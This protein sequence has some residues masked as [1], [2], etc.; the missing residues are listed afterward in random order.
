MLEI[1]RTW[2]R[3]SE[4]RKR[5]KVAG[6]AVIILEEWDDVEVEIGECFRFK[7]RVEEKVGMTVFNPAARDRFLGWPSGCVVIL[8]EW[9][10]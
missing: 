9:D 2:Q 4:D 1:Y 3:N 5:D 7:M 6:R 10:D 8:E